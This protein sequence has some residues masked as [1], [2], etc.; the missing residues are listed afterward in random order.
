MSEEK[1]ISIHRIDVESSDANEIEI[2]YTPD[3][4]QYLQ[5]GKSYKFVFSVDNMKIIEEDK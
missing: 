2:I 3:Q 1:I 4:D 5:K